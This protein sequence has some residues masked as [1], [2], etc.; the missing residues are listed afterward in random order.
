MLFRSASV[1]AAAG[2]VVGGLLTQ[3]HWSL[4]FLI[5]LPIGLVCLVA[6]VRLVPSVIHDRAGHIPDPVES[7]LVV[8]AIGALSTG[9][10][11]EPEWGWGDSRTMAA[12]ILAVLAG[13]AFLV[14][15]RRVATPVVDLA[16]FRD[17]R[18]AAA[19]TAMLFAGAAMGTELLGLSLLLQ[20]SWH[21]SPI[22]T[23]LGLAPSAVT[24][25]VAAQLGPRLLPRM[26]PPAM[27]ALGCCISAVGQGAMV[28]ALHSMH[29][30][31]YVV[32]ILPAWLVIG[33]GGGFAIPAIIGT[34]AAS[35][36]AHASASGSAVVQMSR[37]IGSVIGTATLVAILGTTVGTT[38]PF[39]TTWSGTTALWLL[40]GATIAIAARQERA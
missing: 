29:G 38:T 32:A 40:A 13:L 16:L 23:G 7:L 24:T 35:V 39:L 25:F 4:V 19:N 3:V 21:W 11:K 17:R 9:L 28:L 26:K 31:P 33:L 8:V 20:Q 1:A 14:V 37:Q 27:A 34:G 36:A 2:P 5:N 12:W 15:N 10:V 18:F 6:A 22:A 30:H